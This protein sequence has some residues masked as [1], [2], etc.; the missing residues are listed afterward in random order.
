MV[1][2]KVVVTDQWSDKDTFTN[3]L[4]KNEKGL[5]FT[6]RSAILRDFGPFEGFQP[7]LGISATL[8]VFGHMGWQWD[9]SCK[10]SFHGR[11]LLVRALG[12]SRG[13]TLTF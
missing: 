12:R 6:F 1:I 8:R 3:R 9:S 7:L 10:A 13:A 11:I 2:A 4:A 5:G